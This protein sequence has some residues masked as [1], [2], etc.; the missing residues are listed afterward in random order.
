M[1]FLMTGGIIVTHNLCW[2]VSGVQREGEAAE[3]RPTLYPI[4]WGKWEAYVRNMEMLPAGRVLIP[5]Y[6][7]Y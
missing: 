3:L 1:S 7:T 4:W 2:L 6:A 5:G